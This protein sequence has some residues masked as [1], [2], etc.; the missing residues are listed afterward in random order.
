MGVFSVTF[1]AI[2]V[3]FTIPKE[4]KMLIFTHSPE[5]A[6]FAAFPYKLFTI[7]LAVADSV[8][9]II[10]DI[11]SVCLTP[12]AMRKSNLCRRIGFGNHEVLVGYAHE[13]VVAGIQLAGILGRVLLPFDGQVQGVLNT[14]LH[15]GENNLEIGFC[16]TV[17][18]YDI[19]NGKERDVSV[20]KSVGGNFAQGNR[21]LYSKS[22][23]AH[24]AGYLDNH[25]LR[26]GRVED[27]HFL[28]HILLREINTIAVF[29]I[30]GSGRHFLLLGAG[31]K[32]EGCYGCCK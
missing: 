5:T 27:L 17:L 25:F 9:L 22:T 8:N 31:N 3:V 7:R 14:F 18:E 23:V 32:G 2:R 11:S 1:R 19:R 26:L 29:R 16:L 6:V 20:H 10:L 12:P 21:R 15:I 24:A 28:N 30:R 4:G 13:F